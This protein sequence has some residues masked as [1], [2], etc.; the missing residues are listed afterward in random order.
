[1]SF[2]IVA[3]LTITAFLGVSAQ[4]SYGLVNCSA[5]RTDA[6][7]NSNATLVPGSSCCATVYNQTRNLTSGATSN[8][9]TPAVAYYCLPI[10]YVGKSSMTVETNRN[11]T[12]AVQYVMQCVGT[13]LSQSTTCS[14]GDDSSCSG[15]NCC[16]SR[17]ASISF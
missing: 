5:N 7:C 12:F 9:T 6:F 11:S 13:S 14:G 15:D 4:T 17:T 16:A 2:K 10:D 8:Q 3:L 1:M